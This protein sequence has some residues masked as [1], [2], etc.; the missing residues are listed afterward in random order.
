MTRFRTDVTVLE[1][2]Q[3]AGVV[4]LT[5]APRPRLRPRRARLLTRIATY[6]AVLLAC[7]FASL[8]LL[9]GLLTS[10]KPTGDILAYPPVFIPDTW[11]LDHYKSVLSDTRMPL[12]SF[13]SLI[14]A[15]LTICVTL[16]VACPMAY[17]AAH[18]E[19][20]F[21]R[22]IL[23]AVLATAMVPGISVLV[24]LYLLSHRLSIHDSYFALVLVYSAWMTPQAVW[25]MTDFFKSIPAELEESARIDGCSR[26]SAFLRIMLPLSRPGLVATSMVVFI[27]V[28]NDF[29]IAVALTASDD[30]RTN[31]VGL[32]RYISDVGVSWGNFMAY[33]F[34]ITLPPIVLFV[35][36]QRKFI[37]A[38]TGGAVK[39]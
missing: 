8:P 27:Y 12:Y 24:P 5:P 34:M 6:S 32:V 38:M 4:K 10:F 37:Q 16:V 14:T 13:N 1:S 18:F 28:W 26:L 19:F 11:T 22:V 17:V 25:L 15:A 23:L 20:R 9:W 29:L 3:S 36:L 35:T 30:M 31:Q 2:R 33:A 7:A 21:K 39:G